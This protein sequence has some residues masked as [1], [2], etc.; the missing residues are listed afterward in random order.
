MYLLTILC[1]VREQANSAHPHLTPI[2]LWQGVI[3]IYEKESSFVGFRIFLLNRVSII[4]LDE[5]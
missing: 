4:K 3:W 2:P 1:P 5:S